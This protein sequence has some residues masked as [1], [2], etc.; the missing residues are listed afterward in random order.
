MN[1]SEYSN[2]GVTRSS[3]SG[4]NIEK[5]LNPFS[6]KLK[7]SKNFSKFSNTPILS[8]FKIHHT[9][10]KKMKIPFSNKEKSNI[11]ANKRNTDPNSPNIL[12]VA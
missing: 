7:I 1:S 3:V 4:L 5:V 10:Y 11:N 6:T 12:K 8:K 2:K 9:S